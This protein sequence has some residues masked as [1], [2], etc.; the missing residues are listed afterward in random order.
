VLPLLR[1]REINYLVIGDEFDTSRLTAYNG[2]P[3]YDGLYDQSRFFDNDMSIYFNE[4][5]WNI[6]QLSILRP[7]S[8]MLIEKILAKRYPEHLKVQM[9]CHAA[10]IENEYVYPCGNCEK[11]RRIVGILTAIDIDATHCGYTEQQIKKCLDDISEKGVYQEEE[12]AQHLIYLLTKKNKI[13]YPKQ[14]HPHDEIMMLRIDPDISPLGDIPE[15]IRVPLVNIYMKYT[16][17]AIKKENGQWIE[18]RN[19]NLSQIN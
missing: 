2:I 9:S 11:C 13:N 18:H 1:K 3:H 6:T 5:G 17:G 8:E 10:H 4:K 14:V 7:M 19:L 12:G 16:D 15:K